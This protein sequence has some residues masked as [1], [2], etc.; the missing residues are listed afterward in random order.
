MIRPTRWNQ[1][2]AVGDRSVMLA[3][4]EVAVPYTMA[5][6]PLVGDWVA[7][8]EVTG[9][10]VLVRH[11]APELSRRELA[12]VEHFESAPAAFDDSPGMTFGVRLVLVA[13]GVPLLAGI[14]IILAS[15]WAAVNR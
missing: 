1:V 6:V 13:L 2:V 12:V 15:V 10:V 14:V 9:V 5:H 11:E 3:G 4:R 7:V 8:D